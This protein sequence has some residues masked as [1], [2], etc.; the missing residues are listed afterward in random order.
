MVM[1]ESDADVD[2]AMQ[3][4]ETED[5][6]RKAHLICSCYGPTVFEP[7][8]DSATL[9]RSLFECRTKIKHPRHQVANK[10]QM[11]HI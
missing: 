8:R 3:R 11:S 4:L 2:N 10:Y 1:V 7:G 9:S 5:K 6:K